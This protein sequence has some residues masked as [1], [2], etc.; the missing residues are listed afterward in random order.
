M[1]DWHDD[2]ETLIKV[3]DA[4]NPMVE[5]VEACDPW[6]KA[7]FGIEG[8]GEGLVFYPVACESGSTYPPLFKAKGEKHRVMKAE[9]AAQLAPEVASSIAAFVE[10]AVPLPRLEQGVSLTGSPS[11]KSIGAFLKW[12]VADVQKETQAELAASGLTF[13][14]VSRAVM[15]RARNWYMAEAKK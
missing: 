9:K 11:M 15:E 10:M 5:A 8:V 7:V 12:V 4:I 6:V 13:E 1:F 2:D 14:Q 3:V